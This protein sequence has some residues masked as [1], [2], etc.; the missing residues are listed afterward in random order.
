[1]SQVFT[2]SLHTLFPLPFSFC[3]HDTLLTHC[4]DQKFSSL[5]SLL[6]TP[7]QKKAFPPLCSNIHSP[8]DPALIPQGLFLFV[9][10][11]SFPLDYGLFEGRDIFKNCLLNE[12]IFPIRW[13][14]CD[15]SNSS[16]IAIPV[17]LKN[18]ING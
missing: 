13:P 18:R 14:L 15:F 3:L 1:M 8:S 12:N 11:C 9:Y 10:S 4:P 2:V 17:P 6:A 5:V 16:L 7:G